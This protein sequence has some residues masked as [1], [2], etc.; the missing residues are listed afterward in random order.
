VSHPFFGA[1]RNRWRPGGHRSSDTSRHH[2]TV[3]S[4]CHVGHGGRGIPGSALSL[5]EQIASP[6]VEGHSA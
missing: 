5:P 6:R 3:L 2:R 1:V 4:T